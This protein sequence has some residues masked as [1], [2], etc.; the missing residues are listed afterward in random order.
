MD[1]IDLRLLDLVQRDATLTNEK[2]GERVGASA[3]AVHRRLGKLRRAGVIRAVVAVVDQ[4]AV[5]SPLSFVVGL[6]IERK[7]PD[8][9]DRLQRW[10]L[11]EDAVQQAYNVTG[12]SD[13][14]I[15]VTAAT[16]EGYDA[17]MD[18]LLAANPNVKKYSTNVVLRSFKKC[19]FVPVLP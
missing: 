6:E 17:L 8:L 1:S 10:L 19:L 16:V 14:V 4:A 3:S 7:Q 9:Y 15:V 18:R 13:F 11:S 12:S 5:G 2:L